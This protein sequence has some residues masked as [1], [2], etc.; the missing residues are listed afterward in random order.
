MILKE[1]RF[2]G[3][4][5]VAVWLWF[6]KN[7]QSVLIYMSDFIY[8]FFF[9]KWKHNFFRSCTRGK[10]IVFNEDEEN[11]FDYDH[12]CLVVRKLKGNTYV[13]CLHREEIEIFLIS[14]DSW[15]YLIIYLSNEKEK[16]KMC[17][18]VCMRKISSEF[19]VDHLIPSGPTNNQWWYW[20][21]HR[22]N[23]VNWQDLSSNT[24]LVFFSYL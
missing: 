21:L 6:L 5:W 3:K 1:N 15:H 2:L 19:V 18:E 20:H 7:H 24:H 9:L 14:N 11:N 10:L 12:Y 16:A 13:A 8:L 23:L 4:Q 22:T 17:K